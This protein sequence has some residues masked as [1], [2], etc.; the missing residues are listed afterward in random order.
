MAPYLLHLVI[1]P[2][3]VTSKLQLFCL[4]FVSDSP[5][6]APDTQRDQQANKPGKLLS[7]RALYH[8][9]PLAQ[10]ARVTQNKI[11][12]WQSII[13]QHDK[14]TAKSKTVLI[15]KCYGGTVYMPFLSF[16]QRFQIK[17]SRTDVDYTHYFKLCFIRDLIIGKRCLKT[18]DRQFQ[19]QKFIRKGLYFAI[20]SDYLKLTF[21][22]THVIRQ[23]YCFYKKKRRY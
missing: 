16:L 7:T 12:N 23:S 3:F 21:K 6:Q 1:K 20:S 5:S 2:T 4:E 15:S 10:M 13:Q 17:V 18:A 11:G 8:H 9:K 19:T 22:T 14:K